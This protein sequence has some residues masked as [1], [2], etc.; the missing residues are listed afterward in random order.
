LVASERDRHGAIPP[1]KK[2][3]ATVGVT[4]PAA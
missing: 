3:S 4:T 1:T 2:T